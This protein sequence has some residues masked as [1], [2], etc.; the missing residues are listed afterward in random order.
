ME[1]NAG[2]IGLEEN[3]RKTKYMVMSSESRRKPQDLKV[4]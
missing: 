3:E 4:E 2:K 1:E